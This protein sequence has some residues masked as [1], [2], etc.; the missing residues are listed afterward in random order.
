MVTRETRDRCDLLGM[1]GHMSFPLTA[2]YT[3]SVRIPVVCQ[4]SL[5]EEVQRTCRIDEC[6]VKGVDI[7]H[8]GWEQ[9]LG[10]DFRAAL[11]GSEGK[12]RPSRGCLAPDERT[13]G[14]RSCRILSAV[15]V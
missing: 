4:K 14:G 5:E 9:I 13:M 15:T 8:T 2:T 3:Q 7:L 11:G 10:N 12:V 6:F 1:V